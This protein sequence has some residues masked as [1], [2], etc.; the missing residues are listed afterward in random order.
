MINGGVTLL[1]NKIKRMFMGTTGTVFLMISIFLILFPILPV[2]PLL[3][4]V[5]ICYFNSSE[6]LYNWFINHKIFGDILN[7]SYRISKKQF[8][9]RTILFLLLYF[10]IM[11][12]IVNV[13]IRMFCTMVFVFLVLYTYYKTLK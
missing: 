7:K 13:F 12:F 11:Y 4:L 8:Y 9:F 3:K 6:K 5:K 2:R 10:L 1:L